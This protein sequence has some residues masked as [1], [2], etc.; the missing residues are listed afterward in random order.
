MIEVGAERRLHPLAMVGTSLKSLP[1][2]IAGIAGSA[3]LLARD[4]PAFAALAAGAIL[5]LIVAGAAAWWWR[6]T[7]RI[8]DGEIVIQKGVLSRQRRVIPFDRVVDVS[9][10]RPLLARILG[11]ARV[12]IETGG[13]EADEGRLDMIALDEAHALRDLVRR[14]SGAEGPRAAQNEDGAKAHAEPP[15]PA[16]FAMST[17]RVLASG[18]LNFSFVFLALL[19]GALQYLDELNLLDVEQW[20]RSQELR[21]AAGAAGLRG[22][23]Y[24]ALLLL[25]LGIVS[26]VVRTLAR[27]HGFRL[28]AGR[29][30]LRRRR[31]LFTV[32]EVLIPARRTEA[33]RIDAGLVSGPL[34]WRSLAF[35]TLGAGQKEGGVQVAAPFARREEVERILATAAFPPPG[36]PEMKRPPALALVRRC[37]PA[38]LLAAILG[39][40]GLAV[41]YAWWGAALMLLIAGAGF[42]H[43]RRE[44]YALDDR[45]LYVAGGI[46]HRRLWILPYGKLQTVSTT[47]TPLQRWLGLASVAPDLAGSPLLGAPEVEDLRSADAQALAQALLDRFYSARAALRGHE[48]TLPFA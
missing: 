29:S 7:F 4:A 39:G 48:E 10:E 23:F 24:L 31:G 1:S 25:L 44:A 3:S 14:S 19:F 6:F 32:S 26:G 38:L 28:T 21:E 34:G 15:E 43:W 13:S 35:Q 11:T 46:L 20:V 40:A 36:V 8:G 47:R 37:G 16:I 33:A 17:P 22:A 12:R 2:A 9:I 5:L 45:A 18:L 30:G 27:D 42:L 41:P